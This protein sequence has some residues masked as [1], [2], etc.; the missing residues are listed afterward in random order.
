MDDGN[1]PDNARRAHVR[2]LKLNAPSR[3]R[4][5]VTVIQFVFNEAGTQLLLIIVLPNS[6]K[7]ESKFT[8]SRHA[9][10]EGTIIG[11]YNGRYHYRKS[12]I[13]CKW[14]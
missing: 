6:E 1:V 5:V 14:E 7:E 12:A 9:Q 4:H 11:R 10:A 2:I 13:E 8:F 3:C